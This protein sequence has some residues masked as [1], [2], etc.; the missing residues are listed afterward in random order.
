MK[1]IT[2][3]FLFLLLLVGYS[4]ATNKEKPAKI[5]TV[6]GPTQYLS[7]NPSAVEDTCP[8]NDI[9]NRF[10]CPKDAT[11]GMS[12]FDVYRMQGD[13]IDKERYSLLS[14]EIETQ[15]STAEPACTFKDELT[16]QNFLQALN[17]NL[18]FSWFID[19]FPSSSFPE[20]RETYTCTRI[21]CFQAMPPLENELPQSKKLTCVFKKNQLYFLGNTIT[22]E[23]KN[24]ADSSQQKGL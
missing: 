22:C 10:T 17:Y 11:E 20:C 21:A 2:G 18:D 12:C 15:P 4:Y 16:C 9:I 23:D 13:P 19:N 7:I 8:S 24:K 14:E 3:C 6:R 1:H 5:T